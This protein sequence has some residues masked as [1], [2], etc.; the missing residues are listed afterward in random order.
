MVVDELFYKIPLIT[1]RN[2]LTLDD[3]EAYQTEEKSN[4]DFG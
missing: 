3:V 1:E 2:L 4:L